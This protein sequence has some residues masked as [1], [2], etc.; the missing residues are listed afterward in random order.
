MNFCASE[1]MLYFFGRFFLAFTSL[2]F[3]KLRGNTN[4]QMPPL[5]SPLADTF[6]L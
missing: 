4:R 3:S 5:S 6:H 1:P 2:C